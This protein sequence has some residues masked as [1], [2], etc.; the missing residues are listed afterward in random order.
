MI[1]DGEIVYLLDDENPKGGK[2]K[3]EN[4]RGEKA[5]GEDSKDD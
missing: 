2:P 1:K 4:S 5:K 3:G